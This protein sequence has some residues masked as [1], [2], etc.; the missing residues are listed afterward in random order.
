MKL[1][2]KSENYELKNKYCEL[3]NESHRFRKWNNKFNNENHGLENSSKNHKFKNEN[4]CLA[5]SDK[6]W[7]T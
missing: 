3:G 1:R 5:K 2:V 4:L 7:S 6:L